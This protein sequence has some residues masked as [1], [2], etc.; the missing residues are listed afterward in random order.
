MLY[1]F[2]RTVTVDYDTD[3]SGLYRAS[4]AGE[5]ARGARIVLDSTITKIDTPVEY[6]EAREV[7]D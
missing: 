2:D 5:E 7:E 3:E 4:S 6:K 1:T